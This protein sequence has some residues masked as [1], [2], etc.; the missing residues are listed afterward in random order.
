M[1]D[2]RHDDDRVDDEEIVESIRHLQQERSTKLF[3][4]VLGLVAALGA[5]LAAVYLAYSDQP[6]TLRE[7]NAAEPNR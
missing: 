7:V 2:L 4:V 3:V 5:G 6:E 1:N